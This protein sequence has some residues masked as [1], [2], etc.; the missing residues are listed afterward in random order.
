MRFEV[1]GPLQVI[2]DDA[3]GPGVISAT[4][5]RALLAV[6]LWRA[7][8]PVPVD[9]L[10]EM[11]WDGVPPG[12]VPEATRALVMRLR[13]R[14][15]ER[16]AARI[17]T[18]APGYAI[19]V[20]GDE[21]DASRF[22]T[23]THEAGTAVCGGRWTEAARTAAQ[24]LGLWRGTP[25]ADIPSQMLRDQWV[26]RLEQLR[27]QALEWRIEADLHESR[28]GQLIPE[29]RELT[30]R[31]PLRER[32]HGQLMLALV[33]SGRQ[34][35]ALAVYQQA[36][37][38][39]ASELGVDP[40]SELRQLHGRILARDATLMT[41][42]AAAGGDSASAVP[43][44]QVP[45]GTT[46]PSSAAGLAPDVPRQLPAAVTCFTGRAHELVLLDRM[47]D[48][49]GASTPG[50]VVISAI[51]G[52]PGVGKTALAIHWAHQVATRLG[53]G[54]LYVNLRGF[55]P[56]D[57]PVAPA[58]AIR[59]FLDALGVA[60]DRIPPDPDSQAGLYR[61]LLS[62]KQILIVLDNARDEHQV[63]PL[64][65]GSPGC[66]VIITSR[67]QLTGLAASNG[68]QLI[69]HDV[70]TAAEARQMLAARLGVALAAATP[71]AVS[72]IADL[73]GRLPLALAVAAARAAARP[74][75]PL[76]AL[77][78]ELR[79]TASRLD[80]LDT[81]DPAVSI[82]AVFS[83]SYQQ[84][85]PPAA[86]M[87]RLLGLHPGPDISPSA[88]ASLAGLPPPGVRQALSELARAHLI[89]E[90]TTSRY[91]LH[92]L[93]R[94]YATDQTAVTDDKA[95]R[96]AATGR[97]LDHYVHSAHATA[98][99]I[100]PLR[101]PISL[102]APQPGVTPEQP[103]DY[104]HA[105]AWFQAEHKALLASVSLAAEMG[106]NGQAWQL[107]WAMADYMDRRGY[108][109]EW[110]AIQ[111][112]AL[113]AAARIGD[114]AGQ[115]IASR[116]AAAASYWLA[117]YDQSRA[118]QLE[119]MALCQQL[120]DRIGEAR[121]HQALSILSERQH[122]YADALGHSGQAFRLF[123][124]V[125]H[126]SGQASALN[127]IGWC[128]ALLGHPQRTLSFCRLALAL[129]QELGNQTGEANTWDSLG[130]AEQ[131]LG[132]FTEAA[133]CYQQALNIF[134]EL[135]DRYHEADT[136]ANF[137]DTCHES[138]DPRGAQRAWQQALAI[139]DDLHHPDADQIRA[140][141]TSAGSASPEDIGIQPCRDRSAG[142]G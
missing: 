6:L 117:N 111:A 141:L 96:H 9:E 41:A 37:R 112:I 98:L 121:A 28:H 42:P 25:L 135:G 58:E 21:L 8:Q 88:A 132:R 64:L 105:L 130:Y 118:Y 47:F 76:A 60:P 89:T 20:S 22:E 35:E 114:K 24:A 44:R 72:E 108:W 87:F 97:I 63:R 13:R 19:E 99:V 140:K 32:F 2:A 127:C 95:T 53:D 3:D 126:R 83:W 109:R 137:G 101:D 139:L 79:D 78:A 129:H 91:T 110:A 131:L 71:D 65:P 16:A 36:H 55:D 120:G 61:S 51:G 56:A 84:L 30:A 90:H 116:H 104:E 48:R 43:D 11:V 59:W 45:E 136:L 85:S 14:L 92:D 119:C 100:N 34:A 23:L 29:L 38:T 57:T 73:C 115:A 17:V 68:A 80:A 62:G 1:L 77:A 49:A 102:T 128:H 46:T 138:G 134:R 31:H 74:Q 70:L 15:D 106:F 75:L 124:A 66:V 123:R 67:N 93:L 50:T 107:P 133:A 82:R 54:Q 122:R 103:A 52:T 113:N 125:G 12:G 18:R 33:R 81:G 86:R 69:T 27:M 40:G 4:R 10:A 7:N 5:L 26:P 94:A 39:L 142:A